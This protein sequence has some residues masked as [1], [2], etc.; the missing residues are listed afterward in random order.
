MVCVVYTPRVR[1]LLVSISVLAA[2]VSGL[3]AGACVKQ[4][5]LEQADEATRP[6]LEALDKQC[7]DGLAL[8]REGRPAEAY[9]LL[10]AAA[11][12]S[13]LLDRSLELPLA[14]AMLAAGVPVKDVLRVWE[15]VAGPEALVGARLAEL[16]ERL[17]H[18]QAARLLRASSKRP[19]REW[20]KA[21]A[22]RDGVAPTVARQEVSTTRIGLMVPLTGR[23]AKL[24][25]AVIRGARTGL[26]AS[27]TLL[28]RDTALG[29]DV[30]TTVRELA[31]LGVGAIIG[32]ID[33]QRA[34]VAAEAAQ[35]I[36]VPLLQLSVDGASFVPEQGRRV[37]RAFINRK[38]QCQ[39]LITE[40]RR[41]GA[42][43]V[44]IVRSRSGYG[45]ALTSAYRAAARGSKIKVVAEVVFKSG[46]TDLSGVARELSAHNFDAIFIA[47]N[48]LDRAGSVLRFLAREDIWSTGA[49]KAVPG[50][51]L[52]RV[53]VMGPAEWHRGRV[54]ADDGRYL[55]GAVVA[56]EWPGPENAAR[57]KLSAR[58]QQA[59]GVEAGLF[60]AVG[61]D[62]VRV[63]RTARAATRRGLADTL[64][65]A[66]FEGVLGR[67]SFDKAGEPIRRPRLYRITGA[68]GGFALLPVK[69]G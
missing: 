58:V 46:A 13:H 5:V 40:A 62:A 7:R 42:R 41:H 27:T 33:R 43:R 19:A 10:T 17:P 26:D 9:P 12:E 39:A 32:P 37:F 4:R 3:E 21:R 50:S 25:Q 45:K 15:Q 69:R 36:G 51:K 57:T 6:S 53:T 24:G 35:R 66:T 56:V 2:S 60:D 65:T 48:R 38:R 63:I 18:G 34:S 68:K 11:A 8:L 1:Y 61:Y 67:V 16:V 47:D 29:G 54:P 14:E 44:A 30:A 49:S 20:L 59:F 31:D 52:R 64:G 23:L 55:R 28:V 22:A